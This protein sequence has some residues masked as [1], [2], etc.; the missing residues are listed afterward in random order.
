MFEFTNTALEVEPHQSNIEAAKLKTKVNI[1]TKLGTSSVTL[2]YYGNFS[3]WKW[4]MNNL[5]R[6]SRENWRNNYRAYWNLCQLTNWD[7]DEQTINKLLYKFHEDAIK[8]SN[9]MYVVKFDGW[10]PSSLNLLKHINDEHFP[11][12]HYLK[13]RI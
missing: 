9:N 11:N 6:D 12:Y 13:V 4:L 1:F 2:K 3:K 5:C 10:T 7:I 8:Y